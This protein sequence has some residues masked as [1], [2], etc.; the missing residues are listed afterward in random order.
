MEFDNGAEERFVTSGFLKADAEIEPSLRP[1]SLSEY[2]GQRKI[3]DALD[4]YISA[5]RKSG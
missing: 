4:I 2:V 5:A 3:K 1:R